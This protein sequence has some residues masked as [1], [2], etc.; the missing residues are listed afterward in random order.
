MVILIHLLAALVSAL[1]TLVAALPLWRSGNTRIA[2]SIV[3]ISA[4]MGSALYNRLGA[5]AALQLPTPLADAQSR[6][7]PRAQLERDTLALRH[8]LAQ[9]PEQT[10]GWVLLARAEILLGDKSAAE[11]AWQQALRLAPDNPALLVEAAQARADADPQRRIDDTALRWLE[12]ARRIDPQAQ[13]ALWLIG[14]AHRQRGNHAVAAAT[15]QELLGLLDGSTAGSVREQIANA[16]ADAGLP[17]LTGDVLPAPTSQTAPPADMTHSLRVLV[18]LDPELATRIRIDPAIPVFVQARAIDGPPLPV[19]A[20]RLTLGDL[21]TTITLT[22]A[23]SV[24]PGQKLSTQHKV[25]ISARIAASGSVTRSD[26]DVE[27]A[28]QTVELPHSG[29]IKLELHP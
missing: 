19:A 9:S 28:P 24:M 20:R 1:A 22:D 13:R 3:L 27:S 18:A 14:I 26:G 4:L 7:T 25:R 2:L 8:T 5:P 10:E 16:R 23:D 17:P 21:P 29:T 12:Q 11:R 6:D 15:W